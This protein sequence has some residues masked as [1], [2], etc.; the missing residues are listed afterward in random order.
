MVPNKILINFYEIVPLY[1]YLF[2][3]RLKA[4]AAP[5]Q[6]PINLFIFK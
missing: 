3:I 1:H 5:K 6:P 4:I 2:G